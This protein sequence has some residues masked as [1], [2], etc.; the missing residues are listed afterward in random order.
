LFRKECA[1]LRK[2]SHPNIINLYAFGISEQNGQE[3]PF[4]IMP[5][6][7]GLTLDK[8]IHSHAARLTPDRVVD[9]ITQTARGLQAAHDIGLVHRDI[10]PSNIF[11]LS[12]DS[13]KLIDFGI[14]HLTDQHSRTGFKGTLLYMSPEQLE[15]NPPT[16]VS[17]VFSLAVVCYEALTHRRPFN[18]NT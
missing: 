11:V 8:L 10:K 13:V 9:I 7:A 5:F 15:L 12:D 14:V 17:D 18:G 4:F 2:L 3:K 6:L 1:V 16:V